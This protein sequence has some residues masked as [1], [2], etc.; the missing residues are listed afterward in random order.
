MDRIV[1]LSRKEEAALQAIAERF[2][3]EHDGDVMKALKAMILLNGELQQKLDAM[4]GPKPVQ[5]QP[6]PLPRQGQLGF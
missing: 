4:R 5:R 3:D 1:S 2:V 6:S